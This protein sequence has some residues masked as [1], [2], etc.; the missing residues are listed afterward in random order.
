ML[1]L[2]L[3][4][5]VGAQLG[6]QLIDSSGDAPEFRRARR[7][8]LAVKICLH[9]CQPILNADDTPA[10]VY[11]GSQ[12]QPTDSNDTERERYE[13]RQIRSLRD[14]REIRESLYGPG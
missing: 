1:Q 5:D 11:H 10:Q 13:C 4:F 8:N 3:S 9:T 12:S 6:G 14:A 7:R 2:L